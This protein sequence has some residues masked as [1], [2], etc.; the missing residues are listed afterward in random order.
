[1]K[2]NLIISLSTVFVFNSIAAQSYVSKWEEW[3]SIFRVTSPYNYDGNI[4]LQNTNRRWALGMMGYI[5]AQN[6]S[7]YDLDNSAE[8]FV[9]NNQGQVGIGM[10]PNGST[11]NIK[12]SIRWGNEISEYLYSGQDGMGVYL[13]Q[14]GKTIGK[15]KMRFQSSVDGLLS[16]YSQ[17]ILDPSNG[18]SFN[19]IGSGNKNVGI[20]TT[21]PQ[22]LLHISGSHY[23]TQLRL[24]LPATS[25]GAGNGDI[26]LQSWVSEPGVSW[27]AGGIGM[28]VSNDNGSPSQF[29]RL[30]TQIGQSYIRFIP[31]GGGMEFN[32]TDNAGTSYKSSMYLTN[33]KLGFGNSSPQVKIHLGNSTLLPNT[34]Y[35]PNYNAD[36]FSSNGI[37]LAEG[38]S[39]SYSNAY[40]VHGYSKYDVNAYSAEGRMIHYGYYGL[41]FATRQ[42]LGL[43]VTGDNNNVGIGIANPTEKLTVNGNIRSKKLIVTQSGWADYVFDSSYQLSPLT[44]VEKYIK[45]NKH[46]PG[47]PTEKEVSKN[48]VDLGENQVA[49]LKK[50]EEMTLYMIKLEKE[51]NTLKNEI[52][53]MKHEDN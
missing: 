29:G 30:N 9:I 7:I 47:I 48:G 11:L 4:R 6:F 23:S 5:G 41:S 14:V 13:E 53:T 10:D 32:T 27:D 33:G 43:I 37:V 46:L 15:S 49:L 35:S 44:E 2:F 21:L 17:F 18:F 24:T 1:M 40:E 36:L 3:P 19:S 39:I 16:N 12:G 25:N 8:R 20:G 45:T 50:I 38:K 42:G 51:I 31:N 26:S 22:T 28:N 34:S 52:K